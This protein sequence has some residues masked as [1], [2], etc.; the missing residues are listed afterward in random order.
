MGTPLYNTEKKAN[1]I[2]VQQLDKNVG[3]KGEAIEGQVQ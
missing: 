1:S 2:Q 3:T